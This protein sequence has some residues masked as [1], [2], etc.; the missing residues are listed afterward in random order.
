MAIQ[1]FSYELL[2]IYSCISGAWILGTWI[3]YV[4]S[5]VHSETI[6]KGRGFGPW[7]AV[8][9]LGDALRETLSGVDLCAYS[10]DELRRNIRGR[11]W[12]TY[13]HAPRRDGR[14]SFGLKEVEVGEGGEERLQF[15]WERDYG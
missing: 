2:L 6:Q 10:D 4:Y 11:N 3:L 8:I 9:D 15:E 5:S 1:G 7:R 12:V 13:R 14:S